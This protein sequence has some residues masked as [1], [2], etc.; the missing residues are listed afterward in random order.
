MDRKI[1]IIIGAVVLLLL[2]STIAVIALSGGEKK[3]EEKVP[4]LS[5]FP[6]LN[7]DLTASQVMVNENSDIY[8]PISAN[9]TGVMLIYS[10]KGTISW[11]DDEPPPVYRPTYQNEP[12][13]FTATIVT[14]VAGAGSGPN[15]TEDKTST[16]SSGSLSVD[17]TPIVPGFTMVSGNWT[18]PPSGTSSPGGNESAYMVVSVVAGDIKASGPRLL[19]YNDFGDQIDLRLTIRYKLVPLEVYEY[20]FLQPAP[21]A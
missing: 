19:L 9:G 11:V 12:D 17:L 15:S 13:T 4:S 1:P 20:H 10:V 8:F 7:M 21:E 3:K 18:F 5:S 14:P 16:S 6:D 2:C